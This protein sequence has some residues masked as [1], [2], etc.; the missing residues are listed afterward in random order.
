[1]VVPRF[2]PGCAAPLR[3]RRLPP[4]GRLHPCCSQ[5][6]FVHFDNPAPCVGV[7][8]ACPARGVL[9][10]RRGVA[11]FRGRWDIVGGFMEGGEHPEEAALREVREETG[12]TVV[13]HRMLG[14]WMD[15]Y[16]R[17]PGHTMN[18]VYEAGIVSGEPVADDDVAELQ[19]FQPVSI[20]LERMAFD[21]C[22][23]GLEAWLR[24]R[25]SDVA[26]DAMQIKS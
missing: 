17:R 19:W 1:M 24:L 15:R 13:L 14:I 18:I 10:A 7:V 12:L 26:C 23:R 22:R 5:C 4:H 11:P 9:L 8:I 6:G 16:G 20:P 2:C 21:N 3:R 25:P